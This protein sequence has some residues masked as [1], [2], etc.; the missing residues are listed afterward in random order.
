MQLQCIA[1]TI[2]IDFTNWLIYHNF[3]DR[4]TNTL[5]S[6][7]VIRNVRW[8]NLNS[9]ISPWQMKILI[10]RSSFH[11]LCCTHA[12][13]QSCLATLYSYWWWSW[14]SQW[15]SAEGGITLNWW[16]EIFNLT[17]TLAKWKDG[18]QIFNSVNA[19]ANCNCQVSFDV[20]DEFEFK[21]NK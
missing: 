8:C 15:R 5:R 13:L 1:S 6:S 9:N 7:R 18:K 4:A 14:T 12:A 17:S 10:N 3:A 2:S 11:S 16:T 19:D 20:S 21:I